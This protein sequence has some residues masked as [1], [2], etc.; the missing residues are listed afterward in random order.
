MIMLLT[1][2]ML[3]GL[4]FFW[5]CYKHFFR[6]SADDIPDTLKYRNSFYTKTRA[7][8]RRRN[9]LKA[10]SRFVHTDENLIT[11]KNDNVSV[12]LDTENKI[13]SC[14]DNKDSYQIATVI[15]ENQA[16]YNFEK[17]DN[18][19]EQTFDRICYFF[20]RRAN[21]QGVVAHLKKIFIIEE[22]QQE[23]KHRIKDD[24]TETKFMQ[25][26]NEKI[27][28]NLADEETL[29]K[30]PGISVIIAKKLIKYRDLHGGFKDKEDFYNHAKIKPHFK[31]QID[32]FI[33]LESN[34]KQDDDFEERIIDL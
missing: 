25:E 11:L 33:F 24:N 16:Y 2:C 17:Y 23:T 31:K 22:M 15:W 19:F 20:D 29:S 26:N 27:N 34:E 13:L 6:A 5:E 9:V 30:L 28:I 18:I 14:V 32:D 4:R 21:Y 12:V 10:K 8:F 1:I 3:L 7:W